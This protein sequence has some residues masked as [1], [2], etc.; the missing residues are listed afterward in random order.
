MIAGCGACRDNR[1]AHDDAM[2]SVRPAS[3]PAA[4]LDVLVVED[5]PENAAMVSEQLAFAG[6]A[7]R[8]ASSLRAA[9]DAIA[10][11]APDV[12]LIDLSLGDGSGR[13]LAVEL[14]RD[15]RT[16]AT[17]VVGVSGVV[18]P[19]WDV[20]RDFDAYLAKPVDLASMPDL[21]CAL[22]T[23]RRRGAG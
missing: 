7:A 9:R 18:W 2:P 23:T 5:D 20:L 12:A 3:R 6:L 15:R 21:I 1:R 16:A 13:E 14:R 10:R 19:T 11:K 22:A 8:T 17:L 4:P